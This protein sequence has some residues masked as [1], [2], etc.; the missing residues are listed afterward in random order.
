VNV[1]VS[2]PLFSR[3]Y[4]ESEV[5]GMMFTCKDFETWNQQGVLGILPACYDGQTLSNMG[6]VAVVPVAAT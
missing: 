6:F 1:V 4:A 5:V 2:G 3:L